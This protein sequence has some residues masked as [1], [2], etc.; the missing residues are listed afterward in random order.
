MSSTMASRAART[1]AASSAARVFASATSA[2]TSL[3]KEKISPRAAGAL[4]SSS[5]ASVKPS[6]RTTTRS[7]RA[8]ASNVAAS[9]SAAVSGS[10]AASPRGVPVSSSQ[11]RAFTAFSM[12]VSAASASATRCS[13]NTSG[14]R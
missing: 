4:K 11:S 6:R 7:E 8:A 14:L 9:A 5:M 2:F 10:R 1:A 12:R 3:T 13:P